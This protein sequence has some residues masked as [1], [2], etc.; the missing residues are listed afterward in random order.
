MTNLKMDRLT[1]NLWRND[2][3]MLLGL[4]GLMLGK[5]KRVNGN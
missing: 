1:L 3:N 2:K 4:V 5:K